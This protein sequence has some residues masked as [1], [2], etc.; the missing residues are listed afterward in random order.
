MPWRTCIV[1]G[2]ANADRRRDHA[3]HCERG[4]EWSE[5]TFTPRTF[6]AEA[7]LAVIGSLAGYTA[8]IYALKYVPVSVAPSTHTPIP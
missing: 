7:Y 6:A 4:R 8:Y 1:G 5:L 2:G 3:A